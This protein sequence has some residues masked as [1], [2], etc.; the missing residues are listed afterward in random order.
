MTFLTVSHDWLLPFAADVFRAVGAPEPEA[1][2]VA[3]HLVTASLLGYDT[4]GIVRIPQYIEDTRKGTI[5]PGAACRIEKETETTAV[6]DCG[7]NFGQVGA[8]RAIDIAMEKAR[9]HHTATVV[10]RC[11]SHAGRLG[12]YTSHAARQGFLAI[13]F[14][15]SPIHGHFVTP[16]GGRQGRLATNPI[17]FAVPSNGAEP[18]VADFSTA[19]ASEGAIRLHR[20]QGKALPDGWIMDA[21]GRPSNDPNDFYGPPRGAIYPFGGNRGYRGFAL[22]ML[23]EVLGGLLSG[24]SITQPQPGNGLGFLVVDVSAFLPRQQF[25]CMV[26]EMREYIKSALPA[27]GFD[28]VLL[29]GEPD[30]RKREQRLRDGIPIDE[31]SWR[32]IEN[33]AAELGINSMAQARRVAQ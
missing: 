3:E 14:C 21:E 20:T 6:V 28:E 31:N 32:Q 5:R 15:N 29:P 2:T 9:Q 22:S 4:H 10:A 17:S 12:A 30:A 25:A 7:W 19:E 24:S 8:L 11:C 27:P 23:V 1:W 18:M 13:G 16:W 26:E 33:A